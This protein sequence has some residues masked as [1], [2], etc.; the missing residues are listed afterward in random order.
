MPPWR[1]IRSDLAGLFPAENP[2]TID[3]AVLVIRINK[4]DDANT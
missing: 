1:S 2:A 4:A 3:A